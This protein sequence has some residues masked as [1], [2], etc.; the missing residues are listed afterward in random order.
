[1]QDGKTFEEAVEEIKAEDRASLEQNYALWRDTTQGV[2]MLVASG[3]VVGTVL[4]NATAEEIRTWTHLV[5]SKHD[6][7]D[8][9]GRMQSEGLAGHN[10]AI[11]WCVP[12]IV[13][14]VIKIESLH[15]L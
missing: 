8:S 15:L 3:S 13:C 5:V 6:V 7:A 2:I 11:L 12:I 14:Y 9:D 4:Q 10:P 1:M